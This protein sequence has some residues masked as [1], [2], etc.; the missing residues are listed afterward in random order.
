MTVM[1]AKQRR[2]WRDRRRIRVGF[3]AADPPGANTSERKHTS[4]R[5]RSP[6]R[7]TAR[8][9]TVGQ[10]NRKLEE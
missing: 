10:A 1:L 9:F 7:K 3:L 6:V 8:A 2:L 4:A 5:A